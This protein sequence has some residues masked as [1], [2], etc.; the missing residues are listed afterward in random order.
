MAKLIWNFD[1]VAA[2]KQQTF[3]IRLGSQVNLSALVTGGGVRGSEP[4][5][6][7]AVGVRRAAIIARVILVLCN[8]QVQGQYLLHLGVSGA[9][10]VRLWKWK[11]G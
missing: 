3:C 4:R 9:Q 11:D 7:L 10:V 2:P 5:G 1:K 6:R 8:G